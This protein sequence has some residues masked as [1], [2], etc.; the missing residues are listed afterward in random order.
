MDFVSKIGDILIVDENEKYQVLKQC[1]YN[2]K[3]YLFVISVPNKLEHMLD[4]DK[5]QT[6]FV[7]EIVDEEQNFGIMIVKELSII[8]ELKKIIKNK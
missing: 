3:N 5:R 6:A 1:N 8:N 4:V 7:E 2:D